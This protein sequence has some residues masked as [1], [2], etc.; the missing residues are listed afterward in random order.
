MNTNG[1]GLSTQVGDKHRV[2]SRD[3]RVSGDYQITLISAWI[4]RQGE[5]ISVVIIPVIGGLM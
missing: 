1:D 5:A 4:S 2:N 3:D